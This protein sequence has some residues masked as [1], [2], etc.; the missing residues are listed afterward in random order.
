MGYD[1]YIRDPALD[2]DTAYFRLNIWGMG[3]ACDLMAEHGMLC[4]PPAP[5]WPDKPDGFTW[6]AWEWVEYPNDRTGAAPSS[7]AIEAAE[8]Y[9]A[10][11][12]AAAS[13]P[14]ECPGIPDW[15]FGSNDG[16]HVLPGEIEAALRALDELSLPVPDPKWWG[17][18]IAWLRLAALHGGFEV[19]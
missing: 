19:H 16:W 15:K 3:L 10:E 14:G 1:M 9:S 7:V 12:K 4:S 2:H 18:W 8:K 13:H 6:D 17:E 11:T 5:V